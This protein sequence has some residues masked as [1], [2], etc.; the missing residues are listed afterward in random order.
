MD[1]RLH[2]AYPGSKPV[3]SR[4]LYGSADRTSNRPALTVSKSESKDLSS[5][6]DSLMGDIASV[7][8]VILGGGNKIA[9]N[10]ASGG[11]GLE[12]TSLPAGSSVLGG[13][14][15]SASSVLRDVNGQIQQA[16]SIVGGI[17][18][19]ATSI[20]GSILAAATNPSNIGVLPNTNS[21]STI[22]GMA[23]STSKSLPLTMG[24]PQEFLPQTALCSTCNASHPTSSNNITLAPL[25]SPS[26]ALASATIALSYTSTTLS[27]PAPITETCTITET[28]HSTHYAETATLYSFIANTTVT[29]T[30][31]VRY[32]IRELCMNFTDNVPSQRMCSI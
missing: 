1:R 16:T 13:G 29:C 19:D 6:M 21:T 32:D 27:C 9:S 25:L 5:D 10:A 28:W 11:A 2:S 26:P 4:R 24:E 17:V 8:S 22:M 18:G 12:S 7:A 3:P 15:A 23:S 14:V 30:E 31:T 20:V